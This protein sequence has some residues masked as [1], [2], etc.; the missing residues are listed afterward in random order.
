MGRNRSTSEVL[1][2]LRLSVRLGLEAVETITKGLV[3]RFQGSFRV[4]LT[5]GTFIHLRLPLSGPA[6][7]LDL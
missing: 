7:L 1:F 4:S 2:K 5:K 3:N 6:R